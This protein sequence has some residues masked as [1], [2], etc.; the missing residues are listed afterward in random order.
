MLG[1][2]A[3][4]EGIEERAHVRL[5]GLDADHELVGDLL[6]GRGCSEVAV[7]SDSRPVG[8]R[9]TIT[10]RP[11]ESP[12]TSSI[13]GSRAQRNRRDPGAGRG[14]T[15]PLRADDQMAFRP[16]DAYYPSRFP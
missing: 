9:K 8:L 12:V 3:E 11:T 13:G 1:Q 5:D 15:F 4:A 2:L 16:A 6:V 14:A 10:V 7:R